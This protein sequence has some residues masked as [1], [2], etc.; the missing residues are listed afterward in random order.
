[1]MVLRALAYVFLVAAAVVAAVD[2]YSSLAGEGALRLAAL[3][4]WWAWLHRD[5]LLLLQP[6]IE[7]HVSPALWT[8]VQTVLE[9][10]AALELAVIGGVFW[11]L[12]RWR[13]RRRRR[14]AT[15]EG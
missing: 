15:A 13:K 12:A 9:W 1:M 2:I 11:L 5:S 10:P 4:E 7:R 14:A 3:G 6:A 8:Y